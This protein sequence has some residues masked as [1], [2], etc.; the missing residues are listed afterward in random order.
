MVFRQLF[1]GVAGVGLA[2]IPAHFSMHLALKDQQKDI[3]EEFKR[4]REIIFLIK[5]KQ[6]KI[7]Q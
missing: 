4:Q 5:M 6:L 7:G 2:S 1:M 3:Q